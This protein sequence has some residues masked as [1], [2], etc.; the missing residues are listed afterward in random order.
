MADQESRPVGPTTPSVD[1]DTAVVDRP[2]S[3]LTSNVFSA[4]SLA[5]TKARTCRALSVTW[6]TGALAA[7]M[8]G[9]QPR[10][11]TQS[12]AQRLGLGDD[13]GFDG[14][15]ESSRPPKVVV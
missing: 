11:L 7:H 9:R 2:R 3:R 8:S 5:S 13:Q 12:L 14:I 1:S 4:R 10:H 15:G 6:V